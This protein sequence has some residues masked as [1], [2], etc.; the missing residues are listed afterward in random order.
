MKDLKFHIPLLLSALLGALF[1]AIVAIGLSISANSGII[2]ALLSF[3]ACLALV[4]AVTVPLAVVLGLLARTASARN[5]GRMIRWGFGGRDEGSVAVSLVVIS[6]VI[7]VAAWVSVALSLIIAAEM[8]LVFALVLETVVFILALSTLLMLAP[9]LGDLLVRL[10]KRFLPDGIDD[11]RLTALLLGLIVV[12]LTLVI[13][14]SLGFRYAPTPAGLVLGIAL[15]LFAVVRERIGAAATRKR[16][17]ISSGAFAGTLLLIL[18]LVN[19]MP[20]ATKQVLLYRAPYVSALLGFVHAFFDGD[21]DGYASVLMGGDCDDDNPKI[22]P[23]ALDVPQNGRDEDCS[24]EDAEKYTPPKRPF[25]ERPQALPDRPNI[26]L[27]LLDALRPD[28][29]GFN[30]Y[31]RAVS[32]TLDAFREDAVLF[33]KAFSPSPVTQSVMLSM[34]TGYDFRRSPRTYVGYKRYTVMPQV[35]TVA[36]RLKRVGYETVGYTISYVILS[37]K[38]LG[39]GFDVW[40][41]PWP[42]KK[43]SMARK[44]GSV[45]TTDKVIDHLGKLPP[46]GD[47]FFLFVHYYST[48]APYNKYPEW[49]FGDGNVDR[50]DSSLAHQDAE[51]GRLLRVLD[52]REDKDD[53]IV[54][55]L[56]DHGEMLGDH[57]L[58]DH[59]R[60]L[61]ESDVRV[62]LMARLP[63]SPVRRVGS[64]VSLTDLAPTLLE[65]ADTG[66]PARDFDG[67]SLLPYAYHGYKDQERSI[68]LFT[69]LKAG[70]INYNESGVVRWPHK[71]LLDRRIKREELYDLQRDPEER[72]N[73][74]KVKVKT[75]RRLKRLLGSFESSLR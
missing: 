51:L 43:W 33:D 28:H 59:G 34:F 18:A 38:G 57:G 48:H 74:V 70:R 36:E 21:G 75:K 68:F 4:S 47:P 60:S 41:T 20:G 12:I 25:F 30:G 45:L 11:P 72:E 35:E 52:Q 58:T 67:Q 53:T 69:E 55:I 27:I 73:L 54:I 31:P 17:L 10:K 19:V 62:L 71:Y 63:K 50:Y 6:A 16:L 13:S 22:N 3:I 15:G 2:A 61:Y 8:T 23:G 5:L 56:S 42:V 44:R 49:D 26:V 65:L 1:E 64:P 7:F 37:A 14:G 9:L 46:G 66:D 32:P 24:G 29:L 39:Q 40:R